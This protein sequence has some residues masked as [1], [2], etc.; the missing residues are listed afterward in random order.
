[1]GSIYMLYCA[2]YSELTITPIHSMG[3]PYMPYIDPPGTTPVGRFSAV[4]TGSPRLVACLPTKTCL[5]EATPWSSDPPWRGSGSGCGVVREHGGTVLKRTAEEDHR[6]PRSGFFSAYI[7]QY[8]TTFRTSS[9]K[10]SNSLKFPWHQP[11]WHLFSVTSRAHLSRARGTSRAHITRR[12]L[13]V[14]TTAVFA[15]HGSPGVSVERLPVFG[16]SA[17]QMWLQEAFPN[18]KIALTYPLTGWV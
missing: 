17:P 5:A 11:G 9:W 13:D 4:R 7:I 12:L 18:E 10:R 3:L 15:G 6:T 16:R 2:I 14:G 1:M 8:G